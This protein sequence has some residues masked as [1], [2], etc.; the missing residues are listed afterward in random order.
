MIWRKDKGGCLLEPPTSSQARLPQET[1]AQL[2]VLVS[3]VEKLYVPPSRVQCLVFLK[4]PKQT[5][6]QISGCFLQH[7]FVVVAFPVRSSHMR[8]ATWRHG[9]EHLFLPYL[10]YYSASSFVLRRRHLRATIKD[11]MK[12][13]MLLSCYASVWFAGRREGCLQVPLQPACGIERCI[14]CD[15]KYSGFLGYFTLKSAV[16]LIPHYKLTFF[17]S[18]VA[19][20]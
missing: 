12:L 4:L 20:E 2:S 16:I 9:S 8:Y 6:K 13:C 15:R 19:V 17:K 3:Y 7:M 14:N 18:S 11:F 5:K 10:C 1:Q